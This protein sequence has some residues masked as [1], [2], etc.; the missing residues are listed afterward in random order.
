MFHDLC[1]YPHLRYLVQ[2]ERCAVSDEMSSGLGYPDR[3]RILE[4]REEAWAIL[5]FRR[6]VQVSVPFHATGNYDLSGGAFLLGP[7]PFCA[8]HLVGTPMFLFCHSQSGVER[9]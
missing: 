9:A 1:G 6:S 2:V 7:R 3:L 5:D 4:N 8:D